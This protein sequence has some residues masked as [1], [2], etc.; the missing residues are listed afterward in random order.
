MNHNYPIYIM[1]IW[2]KKFETVQPINIFV[3]FKTANY[4]H[5]QWHIPK[6]RN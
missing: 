3:N 4:R 1:L 6:H 5:W 2:W